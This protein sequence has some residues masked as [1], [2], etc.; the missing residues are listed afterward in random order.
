MSGP[1][2]GDL[3]AI[4]TLIV[5]GVSCLRFVPTTV[6][7]PN[8]PEFRALARMFCSAFSTTSEDFQHG[9]G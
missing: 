3:P 9:H 7:L 4:D 1:L 6:S 2:N 5:G 8:R